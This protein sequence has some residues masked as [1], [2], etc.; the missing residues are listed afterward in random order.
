MVGT[1]GQQGH[2]HKGLGGRACRAAAAMVQK[3][4]YLSC[5]W[6]V[7]C[8]EQKHSRLKISGFIPLFFFKW[9]L[10]SEWAGDT[11]PLH[12]QPEKVSFF[13]TAMWRWEQEVVVWL[14]GPESTDLLHRDVNE[15]SLSIERISS[16]SSLLVIYG[17]KS[18]KQTLPLG[19]S[20]AVE[21]L[22]ALWWKTTMENKAKTMTFPLLSAYRN[23]FT[24]CGM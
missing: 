7:W 1:S 13:S 18:C 24:I 21:D 20:M 12:T 23:S 6:T 11:F 5:F 15:R 19:S 8:T 10:P 14:R 2:E 16:E 22:T 9:S 3:Q 17:T 4:K